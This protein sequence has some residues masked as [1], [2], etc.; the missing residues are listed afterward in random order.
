MRI[1]VN[2]G[3]LHISMLCHNCHLHQFSISL[4]HN[5]LWVVFEPETEVT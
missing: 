2:Q 1:H 3:L 5:A 4:Q